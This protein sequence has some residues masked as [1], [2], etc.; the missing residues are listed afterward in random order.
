[1]K[2]WRIGNSIQISRCTTIRG[3]P[4]GFKSRFSAPHQFAEPRAF[5]D[6]VDRK[7]L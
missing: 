7:M 4:E 6:Q 2:K 3:G 1:M 5:S